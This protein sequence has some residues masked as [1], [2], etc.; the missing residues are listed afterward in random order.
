MDFFFFI[1]LLVMLLLLSYQDFT[2]RAIS[3][4]TL[5]SV[6]V[7]YWSYKQDIGLTSLSDT[8]INFGIIGVHWFLI[9][10]YFS[11]K[12]KRPVNVLDHYIGWGD[13]LFFV[14]C[15]MVLGSLNFVFFLCVSFI[16]SLLIQLLIMQ[17]KR[18]VNAQIPLA[19]I[20]ALL[21]FSLLVVDF[22][23]PGNILRETNLVNNLLL[24]IPFISL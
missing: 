22:V 18:P 7:L 21:L 16:V 4:W 20:M 19:G 23:M 24:W 17:I 1:F 8:L 13:F 2:Y 14:V 3:W 12:N 15:A 11:L 9:S 5:P 10:L 6:L